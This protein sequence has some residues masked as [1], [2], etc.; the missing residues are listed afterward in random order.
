MISPTEWDALCLLIEE[1]WPYPFDD[2]AAKAWRVL[3]DDYDA[4]QVFAAI[5]ACVARGVSE[6]PSVSILVAEIRR[7]PGKPTWAEAYT[8]IFGR[9][10]VLRARTTVRK[11]CWDEGERDRLNDEAAWERAGELHPLVGA[12]VRSQG[13]D[14]LRSLRLDDPEYGAARRKQLADEWEE[15]VDANETRD[16][17]VLVAGR[18]GRGELGRFDP[19]HALD[20]PRRALPPVEEAA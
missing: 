9:Y 3:L 10:G 2:A 15:F 13:L 17:A 16:V 12:F 8:L 7:D 1:A 18:S 20:L 4:A 5:K 11:S 19:L 6:R 14:R